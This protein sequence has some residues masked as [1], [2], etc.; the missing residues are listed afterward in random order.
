MKD[1]SDPVCDV[2][3]SHVISY[4]DDKDLLK[5]FE[6]YNSKTD[7]SICFDVDH[8]LLAIPYMKLVSVYKR[9]SCMMVIT[10]ESKRKLIET[11]KLLFD[12]GL[13]KTDISNI[14]R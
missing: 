13:K 12:L 9:I 11:S 2:S 5:L 4:F 10:E 1:F 6:F 7:Y 3:L 8:A 14:I